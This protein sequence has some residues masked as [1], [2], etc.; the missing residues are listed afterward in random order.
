M[1]DYRNLQVLTAWY[2]GQEAAASQDL[3]RFVAE[4]ERVRA[5]RMTLEA[6]R[7]AMDGCKL[8]DLRDYEE[9]R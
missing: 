1:N 6:A 7:A 8:Q 3:E 4:Y 2:L 5:M 9:G